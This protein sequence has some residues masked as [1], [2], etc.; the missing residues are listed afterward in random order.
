MSRVFSLCYAYV[1]LMRCWEPALLAR[2]ACDQNGGLQ[3]LRTAPIKQVGPFRKASQIFTLS[4]QI[5]ASGRYVLPTE[6][7]LAILFFITF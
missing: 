7:L 2:D 4:A 3:Y 1:M 6:L 5:F